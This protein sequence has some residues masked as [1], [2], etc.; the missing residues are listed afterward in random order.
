MTS[1]P[2]IGKSLRCWSD[3]RA[4]AGEST[5]MG[6][7]I[8]AGFGGKKYHNEGD[9]CITDGLWFSRDVLITNQGLIQGVGR[10]HT[11]Y[12]NYLGV[13]R[14]DSE[15]Q[16]PVVFL[17]MYHHPRDCWDEQ[18]PPGYLP[19]VFQYPL[20][21]ILPSA[22]RDE[23]QYGNTTV[24]PLTAEETAQVEGMFGKC[25]EYVTQAGT[26][27]SYPSASGVTFNPNDC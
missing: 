12:S 19:E 2:K 24:S 27:A 6:Q 3:L 23:G 8:L 13:L 11:A 14:Y 7:G 18:P 20:H 15:T 17:A 4:A 5:I 25:D 16:Q 21:Q 26:N 9:Q 10:T 22:I 1:L